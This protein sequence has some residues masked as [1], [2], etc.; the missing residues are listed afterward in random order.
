MS[1]AIHKLS[2]RRVATES[3]KGL[4]GDG[5][6]LYLQVGPTGSKSWIFRFMMNRKSRDMGLGSVNDFSLAE[7]REAARDCRRLVRDGIDPIDARHSQR[8]ERMA[9]AARQQTFK[10]CAMDYIRTHSSSWKNAKHCQQWENTLNTYAYPVLGKLAVRDID[11]HLVKQVLDPIWQIKTETA[12]R[13]RNRIERVLDWAT[14]QQLRQGE[15]PARWKGH[16]ENLLPAPTKLKNVQHHK[17]L[18]YAETATFLKELDAVDGVSAQ[19]LRF[20]I[21]TAA[22]S[23]EVRNAVWDDIDM[24]KKTW[25]IPAEKM[26]AGKEHIVPLSDAALDVLKRMQKFREGDLVFPGS[27]ERRPLSDMAFTQLLRRMKKDGVTAHGFRSSFRDWAGETTAFAREVI[28]AALA[29]QL[30][31]KTE[32]AYFRS[33][34]LDKRR[35]L[36][37][38]WANYCTASVC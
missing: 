29:H 7:A 25:T 15:N 36:M 32:A 5:G 21:L 19:G 4:Y 17:A 1:R 30:K 20:L 35:T 14:V 8:R 6:G 12:T 10:E 9:E 16:L 18:P 31:D 26:K 23:G 22:R 13:V 34:L 24:E 27:R 33:N 28:E 37:D 38:D 2:A 11:T 3:T